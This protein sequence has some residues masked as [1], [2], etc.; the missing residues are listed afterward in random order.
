M[1]ELRQRLFGA[2]PAERHKYFSEHIAGIEKD[3]FGVEISRLALT[4]ADFPN[5][6][7][8]DVEESDVF[9]GKK[10]P[11][12]PEARGAWYCAIRHLKTFRPM[13]GKSI[14]S[15]QQKSP[16]SFFLGC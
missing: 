9:S 10:N 16:Q 4:L 2:T 15:D 6:G 13:S 8:W 11:R 14:N 12:I 5:P 7:G 1:N 3:P